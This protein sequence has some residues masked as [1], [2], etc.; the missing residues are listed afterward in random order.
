MMHLVNDTRFPACALPL[1]CHRDAHHLMVA[2]KG[3][4]RIDGAEPVT[5]AE[6]Q[7]P[8]HMEDVY[9]GEPAASSLRYEADTALTKLGTDVVLIGSARSGAPVRQ[10]DVG[11]RIGALQKIVRVYGNRWWQKAGDGWRLTAPEPFVAMPLVYEN[12]Y[13]GADPT[14]ET[15]ASYESNPVGKGFLPDGN[16]AIDAVPAPNLE[17]PD[18]PV[19]NIADRP[20]PAGFGFVARHWPPRRLLM[21]TYDDAWSKERNPLLPSDFDER[22]Y[23][24]ASTGLAADGFLVGGERVLIVNASERPRLE[25]ALP[26]L[27]FDVVTYID[28]ERAVHGMNMDTVVVEPDAGTVTVT[29]RASVECHWNLARVEWIKVAERAT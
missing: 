6:E 3:T 11:L 23:T 24:A 10:L 22:S 25:F 21:G 5:P 29:W 9:W 27:G 19:G 16:A 1:I 12:A 28:G 17:L 14:G 7:A 4:F 26:S 13:G 18:Q 8:L 20:P 2:V 15:A